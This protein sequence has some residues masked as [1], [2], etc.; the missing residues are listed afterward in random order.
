MHIRLR[1]I[2][3][4]ALSYIPGVVPLYR[5]TAFRP[6][7]APVATSYG[8]WLKH[9]VLSHRHRLH[10]V[11]KFVVELG[12]GLSLGA[13]LAALIC[14]AERYIALDTL[15]FA[16]VAEILPIF[17]RLVAMLNNRERPGN[18]TGFPSYDSALDSQG[19]P[20][21]ALPTDHMTEMLEPSRITRLRDE[22]ANFVRSGGQASER[23]AYFAPWHINRV[24]AIGK[25]D[26]LFSH[27]VLQHVQSPQIIW[28]EIDQLMCSGGVCSHQIG[29]G[30]HGTS[31]VWNGHWTYPELLWRIALGRK[32]FLINREPLSSHLSAA[33]QCGLT[34]IETL[35]L[36]DTKGVARA[37]LAP[38]WQ[39]L[40]N[41]DLCTKG[42][43]IL[44]RKN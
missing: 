40:S 37:S 19:F 13:G 31:A 30:S 24:P 15:R 10:P 26:F 32:V 2:T 29:F 43:L 6:Q 20:S 12:P 16:R 3:T 4:G 33:L 27:V 8:I 17:D 21:Q 9:L 22:L 38:R 34:P 41:D 25:A 39:S 28:K 1:T 36:S 11:P 14:G 7:P 23:I 42:A 18:A 44:A 5:L 35:R